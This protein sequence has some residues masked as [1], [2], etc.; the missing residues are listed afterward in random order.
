MPD[1][2]ESAASP[3]ASVRSVLVIDD[4]PAV[5]DSLAYLFALYGYRVLT[6]PDGRRGLEAFREHAPAVVVTDILMPEQDGLATIAQMRR[7]RPDAKIIAISGSGRGEKLDYL[8]AAEKVGADVALEKI[9]LAKLTDIL[10]A[11]L[12]S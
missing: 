3:A 10:P 1:D 4:D 7:E 8:T 6:A 5:L 11:L 12:K 9:D 2:T